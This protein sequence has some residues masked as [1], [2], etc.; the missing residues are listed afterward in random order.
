MSGRS[1]S[2]FLGTCTPTYKD[3]VSCADIALTFTFD[4]SSFHNVMK[5]E[6]KK[7]FYLLSFRN[8]MA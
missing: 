5:H 7:A 1:K 6:I 4:F 3:A 2:T 8:E